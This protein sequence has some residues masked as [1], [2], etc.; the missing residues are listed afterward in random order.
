MKLSE[1]AGSIEVM[2]EEAVTFV[3]TWFK[4]EDKICLIAKKP[5]RTGSLNV[6]S[7]SFYAH[8]FIQELNKEFLE[9]LIFD[10]EG[11][12]WNLYMQVSP[13]KEDV[14]LKRRGPEANVSYVPGVWGDIDVQ[15]G[16]FDSQEQI[17]EWLNSLDLLPTMVCSSGS[18]GVH[19]YWR[20]K[21][22][23]A[24]SKDLVDSWWSYLDEKAGDKSIDKLIDIA[25]MLRIPGS[26]RFPKEDD[27]KSN[28]LRTVRII[29]HH[30]DRLYTPE[31]VAT[32][33]AP[34][35][36]IKEQKRSRVVKRDKESRKEVDGF[37][38]SLMRN[39]SNS[40]Q[41]LQAAAELEDYVNSQW[42]WGH[43]LEPHGWKWK[44]QQ[45]DGSNVW[46]RPGQS[47]KS[48]V[49]DFEDSPV[50]SLFST[51]EATGLFDLLDARI[52][53]TK[54]RVAL[55]LMFDDDWKAMTDYVIE[56]IFGS[57]V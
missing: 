9:E 1:F 4:P 6:I 47:D 20:F 52:P 54:Y 48:A 24:G 28:K 27:K 23:Q 5:E 46:A 43:I 49:T 29:D 41:A 16:G 40:W 42:S 34:Y 50:M 2:P 51:N 14:T 26:I 12:S 36:E 11:N 31:Q 39:K 25:R 17:M 30:A 15:P 3:K 10:E 21:W 8:E 18:K 13:I 32:L 35:K 38:S 7:Q 22:D 37:A 57:N 53:L 33:S 45:S 19:A 44:Y 56:E 55:R